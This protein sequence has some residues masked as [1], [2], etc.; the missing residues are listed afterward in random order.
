MIRSFGRPEFVESAEGLFMTPDRRLKRYPPKISDLDLS[1]EQIKAVTEI[2]AS[3]D[4]L[5]TEGWKKHRHERQH[6]RSKYIELIDEQGLRTDI[7]A[8]LFNSML[9]VASLAEPTVPSQ[10]VPTDPS[11]IISTKPNSENGFIDYT[12]V[13]E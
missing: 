4:K 7:R 13:R 12:E 5:I 10:E 11:Q 8:I 9:A 2:F 6:Y 3:A 1:P